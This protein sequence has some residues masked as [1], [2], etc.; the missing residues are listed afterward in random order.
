MSDS[1][2]DA[3]SASPP[4]P[5][6]GSLSAMNAPSSTPPRS[7][8]SSLSAMQPPVAIAHGGQPQAVDHASSPVLSPMR[9]QMQPRGAHVA[10]NIPVQNDNHA[11]AQPAVA[12]SAWTTGAKVLSHGAD[13]AAAA[14]SLSDAFAAQVPYVRSMASG[15]AWAASAALSPVGN[16]GQNT[17]VSATSD[18]MNGLAGVASMVATGLHPEHPEASAR[19]A[20]AGNALWVGAGLAT[21]YSGART[22]ATASGW[23]WQALS[24]GLQFASGLANAAAGAAGLAS[25]YFS[26]H[27]SSDPRAMAASVVSG[28]AWVAGSVLGAASSLA[29]PRTQSN[30]DGARQPLLP[31]V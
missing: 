20:Y 12:L 6:S 23:N 28:A 24:G 19:V 7:R 18:T 3:H 8:S 25:T 27:N 15:A 1:K 30:A 29:A 22:F 10:I 13:V 31:N 16:R 17:A 5:R 2:R 26:E 11:Q 21:A 9:P 4:S 14:V